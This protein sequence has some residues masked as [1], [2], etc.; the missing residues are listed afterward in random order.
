MRLRRRLQALPIAALL[1]AVAVAAQVLAGYSARP[2]VW[3][4][5]ALIAACAT[6]GAAI[7]WNFDRLAYIKPPLAA[8][9]IHAFML[10]MFSLA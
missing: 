8:H 10:I 9:A 2:S 1:T 4:L 5:V 3:Q 6:G 7:W